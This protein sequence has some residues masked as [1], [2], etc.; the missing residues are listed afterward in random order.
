MH[1]NGTFFKFSIN[2]SSF[3]VTAFPIYTEC[4]FSRVTVLKDNLLALECTSGQF[5]ILD[6][7]DDNCKICELGSILKDLDACY[8]LHTS[9]KSLGTLEIY[10]SHGI[11]R[12]HST[13][14]IYR[15]DVRL[16]NIFRS[17]QSFRGCCGIWVLKQFSTDKHF[18]IL[19][20][21]FAKNT[22][23]FS[24]TLDSSN[25][26]CLEEVSQYS[27]IE[28]SSK[29]ITIDNS[30][31]GQAFIQVCQDMINIFKSSIR[32][33]QAGGKVVA[34][35]KL[36]AGTRLSV[37]KI[38]F[39]ELI[40]SLDSAVGKFFI[41]R[42][43]LGRNREIIIAPISVLDTPKGTFN[44]VIDEKQM[45][46]CESSLNLEFR[47][48][49]CIANELEVQSIFLAD[50]HIDQ[51]D[52]SIKDVLKLDLESGDFTNEIS[53]SENVFGKRLIIG[54]RRGELLIYDLCG[55]CINFLQRLTI[56][57]RPTSMIITGTAKKHVIAMAGPAKVITE[58]AL[59][60]FKTD[61]LLERSDYLAVWND[62]DDSP[63]VKNIDSQMFKLISNEHQSLSFFSSNLKAST[64][65]FAHRKGKKV[66]LII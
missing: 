38:L 5:Q 49:F 12:H 13:L 35:L 31:N 56:G 66:S 65:V 59:G 46:S 43:T 20:A 25:G 24:M 50:I 62:A 32:H 23:L 29:T 48:I 14:S 44:F 61:F 21:T 7:E 3:G 30:R 8:N 17:D 28:L 1:E 18:S 4:H 54:T 19:V 63:R 58:T 60:R 37:S 45:E 26:P 64:S 47:I 40:F 27:A 34:K 11:E 22:F 55:I 15:N 41:H 51:N 9:S 33:E 16:H 10:G 57:P 36:P 52:V 6:I 39:G 2:S 42:C 53:I